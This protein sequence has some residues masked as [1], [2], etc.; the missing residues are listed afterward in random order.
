MIRGIIFDADGTLFD[1]MPLWENL[2]AKFLKTLGITA[3]PDLDIVLLKMSM[4]EGA[5]YLI[6]EYG[7]NLPTDEI[8]SRVS[9]IVAHDYATEVKHKKGA[10]FFLEKLFKKNIPAVIATS[11]SE[12]LIRLALA[13]AGTEKYIKKIFSCCDFSSG[14]TDSGVFKAAAEFLDASPGE[15]FVFD[16]GLFA[17]ETAA[18]S[19]FKTVGI[20][21]NSNKA[22]TKKIKEVCDIY[23]EDFCDFEGF[24]KEAE[25]V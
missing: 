14:K 10:E 23:M 4:K 7:V 8:M 11:N 3:K 22:E 6:D 5:Q 12:K 15:V 16:D 2:G 18:Q 9:Q 24:L 13:N 25:N 17:L 19:G 20:Y 21:D 1:S